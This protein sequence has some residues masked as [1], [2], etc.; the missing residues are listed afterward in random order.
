MN[1]SPKYDT[2]KTPLENALAKAEY[3][4]SI[5]DKENAE[6]MHNLAQKFE[7]T[8]KKNREVKTD[9]KKYEEREE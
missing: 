4:E 2:D 7:E 8:L 1:D 3:Y 9:L 5:G 6:K